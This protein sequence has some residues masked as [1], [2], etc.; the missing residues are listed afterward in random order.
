[1]IFLLLSAY[2]PQPDLWFKV[3]NLPKCTCDLG[4][5]RRVTLWGRG[6]EMS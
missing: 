2:F 3:T 6:L 4:H 5:T 1:M